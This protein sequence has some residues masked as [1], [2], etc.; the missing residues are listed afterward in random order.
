MKLEIKELH[1]SFG[2]NHVLKGISLVAE[3]GK[4]LGLLG[5]N[6]AGKTTTIRIL[7]NIFQ[8]D[9]GEILLDDKPADPKKIKIG[10][11]PEERGMYPK[12]K[13]L[14]QLVYFAELKGISHKEAVQ[15]CKAWLSRLELS[16]YANKRLDTLSKGN[17]QKVQLITALIN[18]P[19]II[20]LDEP[21][22]GL[23]PVNA[24]V[25]EEVVHEQINKDKIVFFSGHQMNY[26]EEF[27]NDI[28]ILNRGEIV[29]HGSLDDIRHTYPR[30]KLIIRSRDIQSIQERYGGTV[31]DKNNLLITLDSEDEKNAVMH[32]LTEKY[33]ID[34]IKVYEPSLTDIFVDYTEGDRA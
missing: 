27:C 11:L 19:D 6:G 12:K 23:D 15:K 28:A 3:S 2:D 7:L 29:V 1:K 33:D 22:S 17:Q 18:D 20:V 10:Y 25:L 5:R 24:R 4:A 30:N 9:S 13:I 16:A 31:D 8:A 14:D 26:I 34:E 21:F 32:E